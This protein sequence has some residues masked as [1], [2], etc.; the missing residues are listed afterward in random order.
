MLVQLRANQP[1]QFVPLDLPSFLTLQL[2]LEWRQSMAWVLH[3]TLLQ[4]STLFSFL[5]QFYGVWG[6]CDKFLID[7][8]CYSTYNYN[9]TG[10][11]KILSIQLKICNFWDSQTIFNLYIWNLVPVMSILEIFKMFLLNTVT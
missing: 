3:V 11:S 8:I 5:P 10:S 6:A 2:Q 4:Q 1:V 9:N 7:P